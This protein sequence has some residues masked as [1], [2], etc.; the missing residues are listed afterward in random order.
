MINTSTLIGRVVRDLEVKSTQS[1][2]SVVS[3]QLAV[4]GFKDAPTNF[5]DC[6]AWGKAAEILGQYASKGKQLGVTGRIQ[7]RSYEDKQGNKRKSTEV[8]VEQFQFL[9]GKNDS[10]DSDRPL[11]QSEVL[12]ND[13]VLEDIDDKPIDLSEIPF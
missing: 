10:P 7:T 2:T 4:D 6:V 12:G 13:V 3:F 9:G 11:T 8:I 1:G 5:I